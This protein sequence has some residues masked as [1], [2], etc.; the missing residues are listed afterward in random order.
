ASW[1]ERAAGDR[2]AEYEEIIAYHL[3]QAY[4]YRE[5]LGPVGEE[6]RAVARRAA[7]LLIEAGRRAAARGDV[8]A[9]TTLLERARRL[10]PPGDPV[11]LELIPDLSASM[12]HLGRLSDVKTYLNEA[13]HE[14]AAAGD[15][16]LEM[17]A[18]LAE[19]ELRL[20][21]NEG[22]STREG[23]ELARRAIRL[24]EELGDDQG[25][26]LAW[27]A[28][29]NSHWIE[30]RWA[31]MREPVERARAHARR[32]GDRVRT[33]SYQ[34][35]HLSVDF[36]GTTPAPEGIRRCEEALEKAE[37]RYDR[38]Q[39]LR[40]LGS[41]VA[42]RGRFDEARSM[43]EEARAILEDLGSNVSAKNISFQTGPLEMLA[44][45]PV[46]AERELRETFDYLREIGEKGWLS[47]IAA[48]LAEALYTQ[49]RYE[50]A[51]RYL[52]ASKEAAN[53]DDGSAQ[54]GWRTVMGKVLARRGELEEGER[55]AR[56]AVAI[57][58]RTDEIDHQGQAWLDLAEVLHLAGKAGDARMAV[59]EAVERFE[60]KGN[61]I[62]AQRARVLLEDFSSP[63]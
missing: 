21:T 17:Y 9:A 39:I 63:A 45:D 11:R 13:L 26:V 22:Y 20:A 53:P 31:S 25:L 29:A 33:S 47:S 6:D 3:E 24:F 59:E 12:S 55:I 54:S 42:M 2:A 61:L 49:G 41:F 19:M 48:F 62:M 32:A 1:L 51:E 56:E 38:A 10:L 36:W 43:E 5:E 50:E 60:R 58:E 37:T 57:I 8:A 34:N 27:G 52:L 18:L 40:N 23:A 15:P 16:R 7:E 30:A 14:A 4:R 44:G 35:W 28:L 46:A